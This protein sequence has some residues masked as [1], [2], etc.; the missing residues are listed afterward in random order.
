MYIHG[1][2]IGIKKRTCREVQAVTESQ[3]GISEFLSDSPNPAW[4]IGVQRIDRELVFTMKTC[5]GQ[6]TYS[7]S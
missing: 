6:M 3:G 5:K 7:E 1:N 2:L 4:E